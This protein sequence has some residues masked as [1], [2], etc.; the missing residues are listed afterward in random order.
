M[1]CT[2]GT[3]IKLLAGFSAETLQARMEWDDTFHVTKEKKKKKTLSNRVSRIP[4]P[5]KLTFRTEEKIK[6]LP[7]KEKLKSFIIT[8]QV[9]QEILKGILQAEMKGC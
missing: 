1:L 2:R 7:D 9:L 6:S 4:Y 8:R 3:P 5:A